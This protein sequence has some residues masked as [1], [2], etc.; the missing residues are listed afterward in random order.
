MSKGWNFVKWH[1]PL[2][3][4]RHTAKCND[5]TLPIFWYLACV[6]RTNKQRTADC[7]WGSSTAQFPAAVLLTFVPI[8]LF[9]H[10]DLDWNHFLPLDPSSSF[11]LQQ[12]Q[13]HFLS[14]TDLVQ[15]LIHTYSQHT[16][17]ALSVLPGTLSFVF[18]PQTTHMHIEKPLP[19]G[20][21]YQV[22]VVMNTG[23]KESAFTWMGLPE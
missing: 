6:S 13:E 3:G 11:W 8:H 9:A 10:L 15:Y 2:C 19:C 5:P 1:W 12:L 21:W 23:T 22:I 4:P 14:G 16:S 18:I 20:M 7:P 17:Q